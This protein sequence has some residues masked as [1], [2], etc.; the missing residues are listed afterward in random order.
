M[1]S[2][3]HVRGDTGSAGKFSVAST[4]LTGAYQAIHFVNTSAAV[5]GDYVV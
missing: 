5:P 1:D 4:N 2:R 3:R